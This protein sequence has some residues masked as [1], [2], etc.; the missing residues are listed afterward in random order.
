M[1]R[2][3]APLGVLSVLRPLVRAAHAKRLII[4]GLRASERFFAGLGGNPHP[5]WDTTEDEDPLGNLLAIFHPYILHGAYWYESGYSRG[6][7]GHSVP[8]RPL[9]HP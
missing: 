3:G 9:V 5:L 7:G 4:P 6:N 8:Y 2:A 1:A